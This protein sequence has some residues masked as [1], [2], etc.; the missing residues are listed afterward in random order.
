MSSQRRI[1][2]SCPDQLARSLVGLRFF[3]PARSMCQACPAADALELPGVPAD[4]QQTKFVDR[5]DASRDRFD[6]MHRGLAGQQAMGRVRLNRQNPGQT[7]HVHCAR[8]NGL[9]HAFGGAKATRDHQRGLDRCSGHFCKLQK[10]GLA[11]ES[12]F[13]HHT[14][15]GGSLIG[16]ARNLNQVNTR[17]RQRTNGVQR[18]FWRKAALLEVCRIE[19]DSHRKLGPHRQTHG[20]IDRQHEAAAFFGI[21]T[22]CIGTA[23]A[24][25]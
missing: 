14:G 11:L 22:P 24:V 2:R 17:S 18:L 12:A 7:H 13:L 16:S 8:F 1:V 15:H 10:V 6:G 5:L 3:L 20:A 9:R 21:A 23:I 25:G 19:L 4:F